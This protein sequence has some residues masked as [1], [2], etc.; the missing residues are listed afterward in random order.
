[1]GYGERISSFCKA[2]IVVAIAFTQLGVGGCFISLLIV[3]YR[4][5]SSPPDAQIAKTKG[6]FSS[7]QSLMKLMYLSLKTTARNG[8]CQSI[9]GAGIVSIIL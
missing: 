2:P 6:A 5:G 8:Q 4:S 1:L 9:I 3:F 7:E